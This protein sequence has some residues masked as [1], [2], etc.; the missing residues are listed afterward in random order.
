MRNVMKFLAAVS[1]VLERTF[2]EFEGSLL[3]KLIA[4][5][6]GVAEYLLFY[7]V[8]LGF[9]IKRQRGFERADAAFEV[10]GVE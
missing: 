8:R 3:G 10:V 2:D 6:D 1:V 4:L 5:D 9:P 7:A